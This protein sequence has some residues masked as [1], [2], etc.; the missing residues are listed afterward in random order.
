[1]MGLQS[2]SSSPGALQSIDMDTLLTLWNNERSNQLTSDST[3]KKLPLYSPGQ[4]ARRGFRC[5][6][7][8]L[9]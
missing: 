9:T 5:A 2:Q 4:A 3:R 8:F 6:G 1:M 7:P